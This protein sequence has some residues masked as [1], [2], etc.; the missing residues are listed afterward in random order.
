MGGPDRPVRPAADLRLPLGALAAWLTVLTVLGLPGGTGVGGGHRGAAGVGGPAARAPV[1]DCDRRARARLRRRRRGGRRGAG[2]GCRALAVD[3]PGRR[4]VQ[5]V[6]PAGGRRRPS[7]VACGP[8][9]AA[10]R[11]GC[12]GRAARRGRPELV[13]RRSGARP[14]TGRGLAGAAAQPA[15]HRG[16]HALAAAAPRP[17]RRRPLRP[18]CA[19]GRASRVPGASRRWT[20]QGRPPGGGGRAAGGTARPAARAGARR[21]Q[22]PRAG[23]RGGLPHRRPDPPAGGERHQLRDRDRRRPAAAPDGD[24]GPA[25]VGG[26]GRCG[27]GGLRGARPALARACCGR[28]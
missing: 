1:V 10:G 25:H 14:R 8:G 12:A 3:E 6:R 16:R 21:H 15:P 27:A 17:H 7:P 13:A 9:A 23:G 20:D 24:G 18:R 26:P 22:R 2:R 5:R 11:R 4:P 19:A 28:R